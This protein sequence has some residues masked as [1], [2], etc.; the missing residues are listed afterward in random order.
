MYYVY[1]IMVALGN[2]YTM[3]NSIN[4]N[5]MGLQFTWDKN[6]W[7]QESNAA[8]FVHEIKGS[9]WDVEYRLEKGN[10]K[11]L[12]DFQSLLTTIVPQ[13]LLIYETN[14][15]DGEKST[16]LLLSVWSKTL[17][18]SCLRNITWIKKGAYW[19]SLMAQ[20]VK[21]QALSLLWRRSL[22]W[23][24]FNPW[25][26]NLAMPRVWPKKFVKIVFTKTSGICVFNFRIYS[27]TCIFKIIY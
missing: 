13:Y 20:W 8:R 3:L 19:S 27:Y 23:H 15:K 5:V 26:R 9:D 22:L 21:D 1:F 16:L 24:R 4:L 6:Y 25:F 11:N 12:Q 14:K 10:V 7:K 18:L 2:W 17:E